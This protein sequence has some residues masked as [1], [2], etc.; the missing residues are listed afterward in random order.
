[1]ATE[2]RILAAFAVYLATIT[3]Q[4]AGFRLI[5]VPA[6]GELPS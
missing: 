1:M 5:E 4:A 3:A 2:N 6:N